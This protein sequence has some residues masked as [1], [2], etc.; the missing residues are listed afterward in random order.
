M[1]KIF[2]TIVFISL[3]NNLSFAQECFRTASFEDGPDYMLDGSVTITKGLDGKLTLQLSN[4][5]NTSNGP[6]LHIYLANANRPDPNSLI[7]APLIKANGFQE[8]EIPNTVQI[9]DY[10]FVLIHCKQF[11]H[12]WGHAELGSLMGNCITSGIVN[13]TNKNEF[14]IYPNPSIDHI[15]VKTDLKINSYSIIDLNGRIIK[16]GIYNSTKQVSIIELPEG[17]YTF[18]F[19]DENQVSHHYPIIKRNN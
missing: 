15:N 3:L 6:D 2:T 10:N 18:K 1:K 12:F 19:V 4:D 9:T 13:N 11:N 14:I 8:Y 16:E 17:F 7:L 5:F